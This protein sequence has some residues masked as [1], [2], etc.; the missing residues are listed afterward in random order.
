MKSLS[1]LLLVAVFSLLPLMPAAA[2][3]ADADHSFHRFEVAASVG[4]TTI[5]NRKPA[6]AVGLEAEVRANPW[7]AVALFY[8]ETIG[9]EIDF[10]AIGIAAMFRP[11]AGVVLGLGGGVETK[12]VENKS[13]SLWRF[14]TAYEAP[15]YDRYTVG[16]VFTLDIVD[17]SDPVFYYGIAVGLGL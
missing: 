2:S 7:F 10:Q 12:L 11:G 3:D 1:C 5:A 15:F 13:Q 17:G 14:Q 6:A 9:D 8:N 16:P 4:V